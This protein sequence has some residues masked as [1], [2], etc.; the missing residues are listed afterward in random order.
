VIFSKFYRL[1]L[2]PFL[3]MSASATQDPQQMLD[4]EHRDSRSKISA[5]PRDI[6]GMTQNY[7]K[8]LEYSCPKNP[9]TNPFDYHGIKFHLE[10]PAGSET[11]E[12]D[13]LVNGQYHT[14]NNLKLTMMSFINISGGTILRCT[15]HTIPLH[16]PS[17]QRR[18]YIPIM[19]TAKLGNLDISTAQIINSGGTTV[20]F[21]IMRSVGH[22]EISSEENANI[23]GTVV[24][25][26]NPRD[27][28]MSSQGAS[29]AAE[30]VAER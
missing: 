20:R 10:I 18:G 5:L 26:E 17:D 1:A 29:A 14:P 21:N 30:I 12:A 24:T 19:F 27:K 23:A 8:P 6:V 16:L 11:R 25:F 4:Q 28:R 9:N 3:M 2:V 13:Y 15:Y 7:F 22:I